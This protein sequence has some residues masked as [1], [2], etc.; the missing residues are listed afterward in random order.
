MDKLAKKS[1]GK[2]LDDIVKDLLK[3]D[4]LREKLEQDAAQG[5]GGKSLYEK[6]AKK[7]KTQRT[8]TIVD[9]SGYVYETVPGNRISGVTA[10]VYFEE[11]FGQLQWWDAEEYNQIKINL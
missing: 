4:D 2:I 6:I 9:P 11:D 8:K 1:Y 5:K 3:D 10:S 7:I